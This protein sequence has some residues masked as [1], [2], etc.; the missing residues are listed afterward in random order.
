MLTFSRQV[1]SKTPYSA[2]WNSYQPDLQRGL[3][4]Q[5]EC[6]RGGSTTVTEQL[7]Y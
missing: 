3:Y 5:S 7:S 6:Q 2:I 1:N 4:Y